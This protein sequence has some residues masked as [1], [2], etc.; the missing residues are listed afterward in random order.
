MYQFFMS[1]ENKWKKA[2][3]ELKE[4][5]ESIEL[6]KKFPLKPFIEV[7]SQPYTIEEPIGYQPSLF[8]S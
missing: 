4:F 2:V 5:K 8:W 3:E 6:I 1:L 7:K